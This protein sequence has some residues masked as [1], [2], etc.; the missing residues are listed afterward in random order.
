MRKSVYLFVA[1]LFMVIVMAMSEDTAEVEAQ[2]GK[3]AQSSVRGVGG[4]WP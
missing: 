3:I 1:L 4:V 2:K